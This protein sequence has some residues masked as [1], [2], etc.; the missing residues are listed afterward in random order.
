MAKGLEKDVGE[1]GS[2][3]CRTGEVDGVER[4]SALERPEGVD[5]GDSSG[6]SGRGTC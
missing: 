2:V 3:R 5:V 1:K 4:A 6:A